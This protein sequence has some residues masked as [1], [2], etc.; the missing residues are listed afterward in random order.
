MLLCYGRQGKR[1]S[2]AHHHHVLEAPEAFLQRSSWTPTEHK[3][4]NILHIILDL[5]GQDQQR[6]A[7]GYLLL[8]SCWPRRKRFCSHLWRSRHG[9]WT[10]G[11]GAWPVGTN[12]PCYFCSLKVKTRQLNLQSQPHKCAMNRKNDYIHPVEI[13][14]PPAGPLLRLHQSL[15]VNL[16]VGGLRQSQLHNIRKRPL[17]QVVAVQRQKLLK[18]QP[19]LIVL[20]VKQNIH[21]QRMHVNKFTCQAQQHI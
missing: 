5:K 10:P 16:R 20:C 18:L 12:C 17:L 2:T 1:H 3:T 21:Q 7:D 4:N 14:V 9:R 6:D 19:H 13:E 11:A 15:P 8:V